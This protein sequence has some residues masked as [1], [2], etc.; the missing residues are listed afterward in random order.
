MTAGLR[1][2][3]VTITAGDSAHREDYGSG[4]RVS[5]LALVSRLQ[6]LLHAGGLK[7]AKSLP[8]A[9]NLATELQA[10][11]ATITAAGAATFGARAGAHDDLVLALA[12]GVWWT[13]RREKDRTVIRELR[14]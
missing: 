13:A 7:I 6:A 9:T 1:P 12:I 2:I 4:W 11:R 5:E 14:L 3:G 10:F 8:E